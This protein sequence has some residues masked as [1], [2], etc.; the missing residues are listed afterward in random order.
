MRPLNEEKNPK[1]KKM[2]WESQ[3]ESPHC[4]TGSKQ[5]CLS[6]D[7]DTAAT[8]GHSKTLGIRPPNSLLRIGIRG[9]SAGVVGFVASDKGRSPAAGEDAPFIVFGRGRG[10]VWT[11]QREGVLRGRGGGGLRSQLFA[12]VRAEGTAGSLGAD[13]GD[14]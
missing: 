7:I 12:V 13:R 4:T 5:A 8:D 6:P 9:R 1:Q 10:D 14:L 11:G 2:R 3:G